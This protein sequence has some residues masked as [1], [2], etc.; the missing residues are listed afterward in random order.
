MDLFHQA[1]NEYSVSSIDL[2]LLM[3]CGFIIGT[4]KAGVKGLGN[5]VIPIFAL[6]FGAKPSTG[7]LLPILIIADTG[8]VFYYRKETNWF[9]LKKLLPAAVIGV[10]IA[11]W[12]G[13]S[14][15]PITFKYLLAILVL[16]SLFLLMAVEQYKKSNNP[17]KA[18]SL[19]YSLGIAAGFTT[20]MGNA[21]G[22]L[23]NIYLLLV[24]LP[25]TVFIATAAW[26]FYFINIFKV[27][28][29]VFF[30]KTITL[31]TLI[32]DAIAIPGIIA[33]LFTGIFLVKLMSEEFFR[34]LVILTTAL[35]ALL[36]MFN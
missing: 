9:H 28:F 13:N 7:I 31:D 18:S 2:A 34:W 30:W 35:A 32:I 26:F 16:L 20:M 15:S 24:K 8:A 10:I 22:P 29:H 21:A 3:F 33:G 4:A 5:V 25:K 27:P 12:V 14:I 1:L 6:M 11:T 36:L 23:T 19:G 17:L